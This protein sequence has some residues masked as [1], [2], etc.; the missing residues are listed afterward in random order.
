MNF[1]ELRIQLDGYTLYRL[2]ADEGHSERA[3]ADTLN[4]ER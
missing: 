2:F 1:T 4:E 3:I